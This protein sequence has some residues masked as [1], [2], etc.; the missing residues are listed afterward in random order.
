M[1]RTIWILAIA[2]AFV[3]GSITTGA[4]AFA[5]EKNEFTAKLIGS[6]EV[7][8]IDTDTTGQAEFKAHDDKIEFKLQVDK[9][10]DVGAAHIHCGAFGFNGPVGV[11]L[12]VGPPLFS[13]D[14]T[15]AEGTITA[16]DEGNGCDWA[17]VSDILSAMNT[18]DT[19]VNVHTKL[20]PDG[21]IRG[22]ILPDDVDDKI[23][24][25]ENIRGV[26][27]NVVVPSGHSCLVNG[28]TVTGNIKAESGSFGLEVVDSTVDGNIHADGVEG[29]VAVGFTWVG[30]DVQ[31]KNTGGRIIILQA[32]VG[33]D[34]EVEST[35]GIVGIRDNTIGGNL[36]CFSNTT[37][38]PV[39]ST[40]NTVG[41]NSE[42]QCAV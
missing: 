10:E 29:N 12:F 31:I 28:A 41:G 22:Q 21:E 39:I 8:P 40:G 34:V 5:D 19:Y 11:T 16:P 13:G 33:G 15:L 17:N 4:I 24:I 25:D 14:G 42:G 20:N 38:P 37:P 23:C 7:S 3:V 30:G 18:G 27:D 1:T 36:K 32:S 35:T 9:A 6:E 2:A 26:H